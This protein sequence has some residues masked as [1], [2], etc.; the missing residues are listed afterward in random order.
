MQ[1]NDTYSTATPHAPTSTTCPSANELASSSAATLLANTIPAIK[2]SLQLPPTNGTAPVAT[3]PRRHLLPLPPF[4]S[5]CLQSTLE[6]NP[7]VLPPHGPLPSTLSP[8]ARPSNLQTSAILGS[9]SSNIVM[10][11]PSPP[12]KQAS[13]VPSP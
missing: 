11:P 6:T 10:P 3:H 5:P 2:S 9:T 13:S 7:T 4:P 8:P 1:R 12:S